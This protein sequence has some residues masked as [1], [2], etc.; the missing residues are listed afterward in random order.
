M[1]TFLYKRTGQYME[2]SESAHELGSTFNADTVGEEFFDKIKINLDLHEKSV[3]VSR[4]ETKLSNDI[5]YITQCATES[6]TTASSNKR[7][8]NRVDAYFYIYNKIEHIYI[9]IKN[10]TLRRFD[11]YHEA[12]L[13][14]LK[15]QFLKKL[16]DTF[17]ST[18]GTEPVLFTKNPQMLKFFDIPKYLSL[19]TAIDNHTV[20][21]FFALYKLLLYS[22]PTCYED[23]FQWKNILSQKTFN[24]PLHHFVTSYN[25]YKEVF[26]DFP[27]KIDVFIY[28]IQ[29]IH[30]HKKDQTSRL[31]FYFQMALDLGINSSE[32]FQPFQKIFIDGVFKNCYDCDAVAHFLWTLRKT[33]PLFKNYLTLYYRNLVVRKADIWKILF[34][35][36]EKFDMDETIEKYL[37]ESIL[38]YV[39]TISVKEFL[40]DIAE[41]TNHLQKIKPDNCAYYKTIVETIFEGHIKD[42]LT[43]ESPHNRLLDMDLKMLLK[44]SLELPKTREILLSS[45]SLII[46]RLLFFTKNSTCKPIDRIKS[47]F[48]NLK[49]FDQNP[50]QAYAP[51]NVIDEIW[52]REVLIQIPEE[53]CMWLTHD[54]YQN[55]CENYKNNHWAHFIWSRIMSMSI[56]QSKS[57]N[58]TKMLS[59]LNQWMIDVGHDIFHVDDVFTITLISH[60]FDMVLKDIKSVVL[61]SDIPYIMEF[62]LRIRDHQISGTNKQDL[63]TFIEGDQRRIKDILLLKGMLNLHK[64]IFIVNSSIE[65]NWI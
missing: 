55:L 11:Y 9:S 24:I 37:A 38:T 54:T 5:I 23:Q 57:G 21:Q 45:T 33:G 64:V 47:L 4:H 7:F 14:Q 26:P 2:I 49:D 32:F 13:Q 39:S 6:L 58:S 52:F 56:S 31:L 42:L 17:R 19:I 12:D 10:N 46:R 59:K 43:Y 8:P 15:V 28:L 27:L 48:Y 3:D 60:L 29:K 63:N 30:P 18:K 44:A 20:D 35:I 62:L 51:A 40:S 41:C 65:K 53:L 50:Y 34:H 36:S 61:L 25:N 22:S 16:G 1:S